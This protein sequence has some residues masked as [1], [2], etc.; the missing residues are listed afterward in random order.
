MVICTAP[1]LA[2]RSHGSERFLPGAGLLAVLALLLLPAQVANAGSNAKYCTQTAG[3]VRRACGLETDDSYLRTVAACININD[4]AKRRGC[5]ADARTTHHD[6]AQLCADQKASRLQICAALGEDRYDPDFTQ[7]RFESD[8]QHLSNPNPYMPLT[9]GNRWEYRGGVEN[10]KIEIQNRTKAIDGVNCIVQRDQVFTSGIL[11]EDTFD[12]FAQGLDGSVWYCGEQVNE[13]ETFA[14]D[15][16]VALELV[17]IDGSFKAGRDFARPGIVFLANPLPG[18]TYR[19]EASLANAED[20]S[21]IASN[22][23]RY[24]Q[25]ADLDRLVPK[26]LAQLLCRGDCIVTYAFSAMAPGVVER[27][28][29]SP[30]IGLILETVV[31]TG[32]VIK[33]VGCNF[34]PRCGSLPRT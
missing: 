33:L 32:E 23:Y 7:A 5:M 25:D 6:S 30:G 27:K 3:L 16:P 18:V 12:W 10:I 21:R 2:P 17:S 20:V 28:Y 8:Y 19:E 9:I 31:E 34:D 14:G 11:T 1:K 26:A 13:Y 15:K 4:A 29:Y 24:G 22:S